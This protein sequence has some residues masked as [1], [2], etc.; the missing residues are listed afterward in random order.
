MPARK[1]NEL[2]WHHATVTR[3]RREALNR[4]KAVF[5]EVPHREAQLRA[6]LETRP[7]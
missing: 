2:V 5:V 4:H 7:V 1:E 6:F 3:M